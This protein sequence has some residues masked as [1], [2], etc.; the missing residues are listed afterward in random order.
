[1]LEWGD[2]VQLLAA[3]G[4]AKMLVDGIRKAA[5]DMSGFTV[6]SLAFGLSLALNLGA[7]YVQLN[8]VMDSVAL[9]RSLILAAISFITA[10]AQT[11]LQKSVEVQQGTRVRRSRMPKGDR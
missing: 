1:M 3:G 2:V 6:L 7:E 11:E 8:G 4:L 5:P 10:V 9:V